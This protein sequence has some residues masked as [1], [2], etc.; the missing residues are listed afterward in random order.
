MASLVDSVAGFKPG[1]A[2]VG[3]GDKYD[4]FFALGLNI[5]AVLLLPR[6]ISQEGLTGRSP[7]RMW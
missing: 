6:R 2:K 1:V 5:Y 4:V 3:L 7:W